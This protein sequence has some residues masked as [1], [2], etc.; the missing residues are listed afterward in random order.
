MRTPNCSCIVCGKPLYRRPSELEK[1]RHVACMEHRAEAQKRTGITTAQK[2]ALSLGRKKGTN[3]RLG[4]RHKEES[5][6][7]TSASHKA[8][9]SANP[10]KVMARAAKTRAEAHYN[11]SGGV[12]KLAQSIRQMTEYRKWADAVRSRDVFCVK[13]GSVEKLESHHKRLFSELLQE[14]KITNRM[15]ARQCEALWDINNGETLCQKHHFETHG[16]KYANQ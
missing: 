14:N 13:C 6:Q 10:D 2:A 12:S 7:K 5:K 3:N 15:E 16:R 9:C 11:W 1:V 8:W 4:Y